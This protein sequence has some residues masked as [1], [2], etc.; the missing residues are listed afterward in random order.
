MSNFKNKMLSISGE[1]SREDELESINEDHKIIARNA[2][3]EAHIHDAFAKLMRELQSF[4]YR[5]GGYG[6]LPYGKTSPQKIIYQ[7][8]NNEEQYKK[9]KRIAYERLKEVKQ[10]V[11][12]VFCPSEYEEKKKEKKDDLFA[13]PERAGMEPEETP[14]PE[15]NVGS[16]IELELGDSDKY[17]KKVYSKKTYG[18]KKKKS[19]DTKKYNKNSKNLSED[20]LPA[21]VRKKWED[22]YKQKFI[23]GKAS[24]EDIKWV[25]KN[26]LPYL[27]GTKKK[28]I[29]K[30]LQIARKGLR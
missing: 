29:E 22:K 10:V 25:E 3:L 15:Q 23:E 16:T 13:E 7:A 8:K 27:E 12:E 28:S 1:L 9:L 14:E 21:D 19:E 11:D 18:K 26:A 20:S 24:K 6:S 17:P 30:L 4:E 5:L 2:D